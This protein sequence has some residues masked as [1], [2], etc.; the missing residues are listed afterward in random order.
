MEQHLH[1]FWLVLLSTAR[2]EHC[3]FYMDAPLSLHF[4]LY[5]SSMDA[6]V[7]NKS[8]IFIGNL[9]FNATNEDIQELCVQYGTIIG[10]NVRTDRSTNKPK[11]FCFVTFSSENAASIAIVGLNHTKYM[12]RVLSCNFADMRGQ[13]SCEGKNSK[14]DD[15]SRWHKTIP[16]PKKEKFSD[17]NQKFW[18][19]WAGPKKS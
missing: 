15:D 2:L 18:D 12:S 10:I 13:R 6:I 9:P 19:E 16:K 7:V 11:G 8:K 5:I 17:S 3:T 4:F 14:A 1:E